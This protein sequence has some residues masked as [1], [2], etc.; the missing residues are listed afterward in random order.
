MLPGSIQASIEA[1]LQHKDMGTA[2]DLEAF[3]DELKET[4]WHAEGVLALED[5]GAI[6]KLFWTHFGLSGRVFGRFGRFWP[7]LA[8]FSG[9]FFGSCYRPNLPQARRSRR[10]ARIGKTPAMEIHWQTRLDRAPQPCDDLLTLKMMDFLLRMM[11]FL[12]RMMDFLLKMMDFLLRMM[13]FV[14][15]LGEPLGWFH[16]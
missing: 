1:L 8:V 16:R 2:A 11:D 6:S 7:F 5:N 13:D 9:S 14:E 3:K 4:Q 15:P 10:S 12:L